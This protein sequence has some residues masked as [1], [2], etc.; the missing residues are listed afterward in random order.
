MR[1]L[2][3]KLLYERFCPALTTQCSLLFAPCLH[4]FGFWWIS[5]LCYAGA[6]RISM[7]VIFIDTN[8]WHTNIYSTRIFSRI[9]SWWTNNS[10]ECPFKHL[11][12][13]AQNFYSERLLVRISPPNFSR[14]CSW[15]THNAR[16][17][18]R[19]MLCCC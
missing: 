8:S 19:M 10:R 16:T 15:W 7:L 1:I 9:C 13:L 14:I 12:I 4:P 6:D 11:E 2:S 18:L 3:A 5:P 17:A